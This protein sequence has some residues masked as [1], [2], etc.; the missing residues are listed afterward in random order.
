[1]AQPMRAALLAAL[2]AAATALKF[3]SDGTFKVVQLSDL[4]FGERE[5]L[6]RM[7]QQVRR[8]P[9]IGH[10]SDR[11]ALPQP[12]PPQLLSPSRP[13]EAPQP[14]EAPALQ[15]M[16]AILKAESPDFIALSGDMVSGYAWNQTQGW[17]SSMCAAP[18]PSPAAAAGPLVG[19]LAHGLAHGLHYGLARA[20]PLP[21]VKGAARPLTQWTSTARRP[22]THTPAAAAA[23]G[24]RASA[25]C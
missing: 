9:A 18:P 24:G 8:R 6:D 15:A 7:S 2:L 22:L 1:M 12:A 11:A 21:R 13:L 23:A 19:S 25:R 4:H 5:E 16:L 10:L 3:R 14:L 20:P 17:Y